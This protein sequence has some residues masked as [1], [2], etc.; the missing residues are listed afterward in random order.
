MQS[1]VQLTC[2]QELRSDPQFLWKYKELGTARSWRI[3]ASGCENELHNARAIMIVWHWHKGIRVDQ[4]NKTESMEIEFH[5]YNPLIFDMPVKKMHLMPGTSVNPST[6]D[7]APHNGLLVRKRNE[8]PLN[9]T[10]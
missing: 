5:S 9:N 7:M 8:D 10:T 3:K 6:T 1:R 2:L 4:Q